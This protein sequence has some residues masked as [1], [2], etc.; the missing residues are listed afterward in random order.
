VLAPP[1]RQKSAD[2]VAGLQHR[3]RDRRTARRRL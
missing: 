3:Q 1:R 2:A